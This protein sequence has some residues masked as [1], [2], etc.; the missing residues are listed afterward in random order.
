MR[1]ENCEIKFARKIV[2]AD[3]S[4]WI[5]TI[6]F[7]LESRYIISSFTEFAVD[8]V[9]NKWR[10]QILLYMDRIFGDNL[11]VNQLRNFHESLFIIVV[12]IIIRLFTGWNVDTNFG[13]DKEVDGNDLHNL[14]EE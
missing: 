8:G 13:L 4:D 12:W 1:V 3:F 14:W 2:S 5:K 6:E 9:L 10:E 11:L 7:L